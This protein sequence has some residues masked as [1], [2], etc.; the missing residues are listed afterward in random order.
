MTSAGGGPSGRPV[1]SLTAPGSKPAYRSHNYRSLGELEDP[2]NIQALLNQVS[3]KIS[4][5]AHT[6]RAPFTRSVLFVP[7]N[8]GQITLHPYSVILSEFTHG[9][10]VMTSSGRQHTS[11]TSS[12]TQKMR[13]TTPSGS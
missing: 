11:M 4:T 7:A 3:I 8:G 1:A 9:L 2:K 13:C 12:K 10:I 5:K 6:N